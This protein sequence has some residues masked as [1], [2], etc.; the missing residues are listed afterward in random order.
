MTFEASA[1]FVHDGAVGSHGSADARVRII[2][3]DANIALYMRYV[4][5]ITYILG[6]FESLRNYV[7][8]SA[9]QLV[10]FGSA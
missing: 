5:F 2:T 8:G 3:D 10:F 7:A 6:I 9:V 4:Y 1:L